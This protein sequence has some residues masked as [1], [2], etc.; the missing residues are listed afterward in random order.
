MESESIPR[1]QCYLLIINHLN[2]LTIGM[3]IISCVN[4]FF[5]A[6]MINGD[7][8]KSHDY[9]ESEATF[10]QDYFH[11]TTRFTD[12]LFIE[13]GPHNPK[14]Q[15]RGEPKTLVLWREMW[16]VIVKL[17]RFSPLHR[18]KQNYWLGSKCNY[19]IDLWIIVY[20]RCP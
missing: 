10:L 13:H 5:N 14:D 7:K 9:V 19:R 12:Y 6:L 17:E 15:N 16:M 20:E 2:C 3:H 11:Y 4:L 18:S 1:W 8:F